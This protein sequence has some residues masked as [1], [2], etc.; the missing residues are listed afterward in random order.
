LPTRFAPSPTGHLH[1]GHAFSAI[2]AWNISQKT[3]K[4]FIIR[5]EDIDFQRCKVEYEKQIFDD[6]EW[7]GLTWEKPVIRQ[8]NRFNSYR[9]AIDILG[10]KNLIYPCSCTRKDINEALSAPQNNKIPKIYTCACRNRSMSEATKTDNI[11][12]NID[13]SINYLKKLNHKSLVFIDDYYQQ[14]LINISFE[15]QHLQEDIIV[16]RKEIGTSY[17]LSVVVDDAFQDITHVVRGA[18]LFSSTPIQRLLQELL[19]L[20]QP[21]YHH[22][23]LILDEDGKRLAKREASTALSILRESGVKPIELKRSLDLIN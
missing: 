21:L 10:N 3:D 9:E 2:T 4:K 8:K 16:A 12:I 6:L 11:R 7:L 13:K 19:E 5:I 14:N 22:H 23:R 20:P 1:L 18:D 17:H 15:S